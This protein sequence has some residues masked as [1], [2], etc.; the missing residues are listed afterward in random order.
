MCKSRKWVS[1]VPL[2]CGLVPLASPLLAAEPFDGTWRAVVV[3]ADVGDVKGYTWRFPVTV[4]AGQLLGRY[5]NP[6][7]PQ[8]SGTL[9]GKI[10]QS[11]TALLSM[12]GQT[13]KPEYS[14]A[15][16]AAHR[17]FDY[18]ANVQFDGASGSG[19]RIGQRPCDLSFSKN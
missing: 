12:R 16:I 15:H 11:G 2:L 7:D 10:G 3:C 19:Q 1:L 14:L 9:S 4:R 8:N 5:V 17:S 18:T 13:G 6:S